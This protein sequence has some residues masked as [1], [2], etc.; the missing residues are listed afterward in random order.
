MIGN[1]K[2]NKIHSKICVGFG[3]EIKI[4]KLVLSD[5]CDINDKKKDE[6]IGSKNGSPEYGSLF[7]SCLT[8]SCAAC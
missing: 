1:L 3:M 5:K 8:G 4:L 7:F 2:G 6:M